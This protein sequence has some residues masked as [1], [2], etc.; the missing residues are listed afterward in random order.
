MPGGTMARQVVLHR[1]ASCP[2][3]LAAISVAP[4]I[5]RDRISRAAWLEGT[6]Q[7]CPNIWQQ[8]HF[9][10]GTGRRRAAGP[11]NSKP[12]PCSLALRLYHSIHATRPAARSKPS[13]D[14][15][16]GNSAWPGGLLAGKP[17]WSNALRCSP[18]SVFLFLVR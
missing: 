13:D 1:A 8:T 12:P 17:T 3:R 15:I 18:T 16:K 7:S 6:L 11:G 14:Q 10:V 9:L 2:V 4:R 5:W